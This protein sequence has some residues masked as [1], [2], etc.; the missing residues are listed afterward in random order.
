MNVAQNNLDLAEYKFD[1]I[2]VT[3]SYGLS[4]DDFCKG[5]NNINEKMRLAKMKALYPKEYKELVSEIRKWKSIVTKLDGHVKHIQTLNDNLK[6]IRD[7]AITTQR[8]E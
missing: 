4:K 1:D 2:I 3:P 5:T 7:S 8:S 6:K